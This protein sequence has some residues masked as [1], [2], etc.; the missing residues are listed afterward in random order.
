MA[1]TAKTAV[2]R[3]ELEDLAIH[4]EDLAEHVAVLERFTKPDR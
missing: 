3:R 4:Y 2:A 1:K